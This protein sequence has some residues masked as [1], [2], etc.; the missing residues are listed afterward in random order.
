[1]GH[2]L[3]P[4]SNAWYDRLSG[5]QQGYFY[6]WKSG[7][8]DFN[9]EEAYMDLVRRYLSA[10]KDVLDIGCGHGDVAVE[11]TAHCRSVFAYDRISGYIEL[12]QA[13]AAET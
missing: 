7:V 9:G 2:G 11:I 12:A 5:M 1:M 6:P 4:H 13:K 3:T 10:D 8:G